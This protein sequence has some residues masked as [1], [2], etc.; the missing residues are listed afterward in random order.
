MNREEAYALL[1]EYTL[2]EAARR[3][4]ASDDE[5]R[6]LSLD[7][8]MNTELTDFQRLQP[9]VDFPDRSVSATTFDAEQANV[10]FT[11][12]RESDDTTVRSRAW[13]VLAKTC[14]AAGAR[15]PGKKVC[16]N[17]EKS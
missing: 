11:I 12:G 3:S 1:C 13:S 15:P 14:P 7:Q 5:L 17:S 16:L 9:F 10:V 6:A 2:S 8:L 4:L